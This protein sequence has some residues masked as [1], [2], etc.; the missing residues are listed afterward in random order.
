MRGIETV[1]SLLRPRLS[2]QLTDDDTKDR[3]TPAETFVAHVYDY[4]NNRTLRVCGALDRPDHA[5]VVDT[6]AQ[7]LPSDEE[8]EA[9]VEM[10]ANQSEY[11]AA[12][13]AGDLLPYRPMPPLVQTETPDGRVERTVAVDSSRPRLAGC[14]ASSAST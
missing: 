5:S 14:T 4:R 9:A 7:P 3:P 13:R 12:I 11:G 8:F 10:L 2:L 1:M 6:A